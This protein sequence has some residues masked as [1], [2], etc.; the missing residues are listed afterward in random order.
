MTRAQF[1]T[2]QEHNW[3]ALSLSHRAQLLRSQF[4]A[5]ILVRVLFAYAGL[6][7]ASRTLSRRQYIRSPPPFFTGATNMC[8]EPRIAPGYLLPLF[9]TQIPAPWGILQPSLELRTPYGGRKGPTSVLEDL[10]P[11]AKRLSDCQAESKTRPRSKRAV[12][13]GRGTTVRHSETSH[14]DRKIPQVGK[15]ASNR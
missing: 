10:N 6:A 11:S 3:A 14:D 15:D 4:A 1:G 2:W 5:P 8:W 7:L 9:H 13:I 12:A